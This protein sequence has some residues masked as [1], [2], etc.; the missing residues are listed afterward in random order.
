MCCF[1]CFICL[2]N[3]FPFSL[4]YFP[5]LNK[6]KLFC[7]RDKNLM[8][9]Y[10]IFKHPYILIEDI[11]SKHQPFY[12]EYTGDLPRLNLNSPTLCCPFQENKRYKPSVKR[13]QTKSGF[14]ELCYIKFSDYEKHVMEFEHREYAKDKTNY[15]KID[16]FINSFVAPENLEECNPPSSPT[17]RMTPGSSFSENGSFKYTPNGLYVGHTISISRMSSSEDDF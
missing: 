2:F 9:N 1:F 13:K 11:K 5:A 10:T 8:R 17:L 4:Q 3:H 6:I 7:L 15:K 12:K 16:M 14:C